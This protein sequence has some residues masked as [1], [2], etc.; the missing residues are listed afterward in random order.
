MRRWFEALLFINLLV[1]WPKRTGAQTQTCCMSAVNLKATCQS[2]A[3]TEEDNNLMSNSQTEMTCVQNADDRYQMCLSSVGTHSFCRSSDLI[4]D[5]VC[6]TL[7]IGG[8]NFFK[9]QYNA[10]VVA[11]DN[12]FASN[13]ARCLRQFGSTC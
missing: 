10:S 6:H 2:T 12:S 3:A 5:A 9:S 13:A 1:I 11:S 4:A 8:I 7:A